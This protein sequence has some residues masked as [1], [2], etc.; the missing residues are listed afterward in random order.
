MPYPGRFITF[1]GGD[2]AGK[3]TQIGLLC[4]A[5]F[6]AKVD[7][8]RTREPGGTEG[9][10]AIRE[11]LVTGSADRWDAVTETLLHFAARRDH[12]EKL[13]RPALAEGKWVVCDRFADS[14]LA[15]QG[16]GHGVSHAFIQA[17]QEQTLEGLA[18]DLTILLDV[19]PEAGLK[20]TGS[21]ADNDN[22]ENRY[23]GMGTPFH[24][25]LREGFLA[26]AKE[27]DGRCVVIEAAQKV[28]E[29]HASVIE[30]VNNRLQL[31]LKTQ[32]IGYA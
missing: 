20:R 11:L 3:T 17:L 8:I 25:R 16:Y 5:L 7:Y 15:Y 4:D 10:N 2:G 19:D 26:I 6:A 31:N 24:K 28:G 12:V 13:I 29:V 23:E 9:G 22:K 14:T 1:E 27:H 30:A 21:R 18:P 32:P